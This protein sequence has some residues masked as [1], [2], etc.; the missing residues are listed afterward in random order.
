MELGLL[1]TILLTP[2]AGTEVEFTAKYNLTFTSIIILVNINQLSIYINNS[3]VS[4]TLSLTSP[5]IVNANDDIKF[6]VSRDYTKLS[7]IEL[8]GNTLN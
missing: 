8:V 7:K 3:L 2:L 5:I 6:V 4:T 1:Y